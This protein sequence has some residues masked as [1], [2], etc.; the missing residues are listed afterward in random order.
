MSN[1]G[2]RVYVNNS[3]QLLVSGANMGS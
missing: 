3:W 1:I 2:T